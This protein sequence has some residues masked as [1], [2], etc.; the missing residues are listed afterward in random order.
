MELLSLKK[1]PS[2]YSDTQKLP[3]VYNLTNFQTME[4]NKDITPNKNWNDRKHAKNN[5]N[6]N[7]TYRLKFKHITTNKYLNIKNRK[8]CK[9]GLEEESRNLQLSSRQG[10]WVEAG[11]SHYPSDLRQVGAGAPNHLPGN[12]FSGHKNQE[13]TQNK[14]QRQELNQNRHLQRQ[15][16]AQ[17]QRWGKGGDGMGHRGVWGAAGG[18]GG[19][20]G[21]L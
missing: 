13:Q 5:T 17:H 21:G 20:W 15:T 8:A 9:G 12:T 18:I 16:R 4:Y 1:T 14:N 3:K 6:I 19:G 10:R 2:K 7:F 11:A